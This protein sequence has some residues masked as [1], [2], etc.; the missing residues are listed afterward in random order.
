M[1][2]QRVGG[3]WRLEGGSESRRKDEQ[4]ALYSLGHHLFDLRLHVAVHSFSFK[5]NKHREREWL[6]ARSGSSTSL[7]RGGFAAALRHFESNTANANRGLL[8]EGRGVIFGE[9]LVLGSV[10]VEEQEVVEVADAVGQRA[11]GEVFGCVGHEVPNHSLTWR[12]T[13]PP[14]TTESVQLQ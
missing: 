12:N 6:T 11:N 1:L 3:Q 10:G 5:T 9:H 7:H 8:T 13:A 2:P 14:P 4:E